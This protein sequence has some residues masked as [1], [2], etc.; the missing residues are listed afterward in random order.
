MS[1][2]GAFAFGVVIGWFVYF[3]NR[4]RKGEVQFADLTSLLGVIGG[5]AVTALFGP[6]SG[7]LFGCYGIGLAIGFFAYFAVLVIMVRASNGQFEATYFLDGRRKFLPDGWT[8]PG[9]TRQ[10]TVAM[11]PQQSGTIHQAGTMQSGAPPVV[12]PSPLSRAVDARDQALAA[13]TEAQRELLRRISAADSASERDA[14]QTALVDVTERLD[15]L[16]DLR[17]RDI[18]QSEAVRNALATLGN[19]TGDLSRTAREMKQATD[20]L[21]KAAQLTDRAT[22]ALGVFTAL[23]A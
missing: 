23:L 6:G 11:T 2:W 20:V 5:A 14:L 22:K 19:I 3:T 1:E 10:P 7:V 13:M 9:D 12:G 17:L 8:I 15:A 16:A 4:Y 21:T 18:L